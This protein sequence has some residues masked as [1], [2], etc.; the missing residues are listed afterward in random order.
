VSPER[1]ELVI[2]TELTAIRLCLAPIRP[3]KPS[4]RRTPTP[5]RSTRD[6][7][8]GPVSS[9]RPN[10]RLHA[11]IRNP[12]RSSALVPTSALRTVGRARASGQPQV[13][14]NERHIPLVNPR[15]FWVYSGTWLFLGQRARRRRS[16]PHLAPVRPYRRRADLC[17]GSAGS[18]RPLPRS[19]CL[20]GR[21]LPPQSPV[22]RPADRPP[23]H[24]VAWSCSKRTMCMAA[25]CTGF[26]TGRPRRAGVGPRID[27]VEYASLDCC[28][29]EYAP[30]S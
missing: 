5:P 3:P 21:R 13:I 17:P 20:P 1:G 23:H 18:V 2:R 8:N 10:T 29:V 14:A 15:R 12:L 16:W 4:L 19:I 26:P 30:F 25:N 28:R 11:H 9:T 27:C 22:R 24:S 7:C 6:R